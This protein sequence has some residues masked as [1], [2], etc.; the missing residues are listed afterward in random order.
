MRCEKSLAAILLCV[1]NFLLVGAKCP[2]GAIQ[3]LSASDCFSYQFSSKLWF[4]AEIGCASLGGSGD[5][6]SNLVSVHES[7]TNNFI[8][9]QMGGGCI[10]RFWLGANTEGGQWRWADGSAFTFTNW[11]TGTTLFYNLCL[12]SDSI[13]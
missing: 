6:G 10:A 11:A 3:G 5:G 8:L 9:S 12:C 7:S 4:D 13:L 1:H 2:M